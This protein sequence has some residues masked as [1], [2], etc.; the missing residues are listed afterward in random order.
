LKAG[1]VV[2]DRID[3][4]DARLIIIPGKPDK[5]PKIWAIHHLRMHKLG[6]TESWPFKATPATGG[7][8]GEIQVEGGFGPRGRNEP[9]DT[10]LNGNFNFEQADLSVFKGIAGTL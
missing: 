8:P 6:S 7:P 4:N 1:G 5:A 9:G 10:P 2:L 3:A